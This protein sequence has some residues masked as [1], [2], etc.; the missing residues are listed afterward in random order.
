MQSRVDRA[1]QF[2]PFDALKGFHEMLELQEKRN[3]LEQ[4]KTYQ[5]LENIL[6]S[7][8][9]DDKVK[10]AYYYDLEYLE[11]I[12]LVKEVNYKK[13]TLLVSRSEIPFQDIVLIERKN[14]I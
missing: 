8:R 11:T 4:E 6:L 5:N 1:S 14:S 9:K 7:L 10:V 3:L 2:L 13:K 12:G